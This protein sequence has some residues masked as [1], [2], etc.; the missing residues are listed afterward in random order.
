MALNDPTLVAKEYSTEKGLAGRAAAY[1]PENVEGPDAN[2]MAL[3]AVAEAAPRRV[4]EAGCGW[5]A[6][7]AAVIA[8]TGAEL[9][10]IDISPRMVE[11]ARE[12]GVDARVGTV[13]DLPFAG[14]TFDVA[15]ANWMLY[16]VPDLDCG[17]SEL[18]RVVRRGG[19]LVAVTNGLDHFRELAEL[20]GV[21]RTSP[22]HA[23][24]GAAILA[25]HF[26]H[27][28]RRDASGWVTFPTYEDALGYVESSQ[29]LRPA[30]GE[31]P[32]FEGPLRVRR[33]PHVFV[34]TR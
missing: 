34:A 5:G 17:L 2:V 30:T 28:E 22:F 18:A 3:D 27:V 25:R 31:L 11:L 33:S 16:H 15:V 9:V 6:F 4:L 13:E 20:V 10:A 19:R 1:K 14:E 26:S 8:R 7:A 23:E 12:R 21:T 29:T 32:R 24:G